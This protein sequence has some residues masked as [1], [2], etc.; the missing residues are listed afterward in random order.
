MVRCSWR[1]TVPALA[2]L[3]ASWMLAGCVDERII[4]RDREL[5]SQPQE[6]AGGFIGY[7]NEADK[8][9]VCGNCHVS[10]QARWEETGHADAWA[11]LQSSGHAQGF[12]ESCHA[13]TALGNVAEGQVGHDATKEARY[14]DVQCE[15][16]HGPGL[17][18]V[19]VPDALGLQPLAPMTVGQDM[20]F[21][22]GQCHAGAHHPFVEEWATSKHGAVLAT[23]AGRAEC[24]ECHTGEDVLRAWGI[25]ANY[26]ER[27]S[28]NIPG[29]H[30]AITCGVCH[31][32]H[33]LNHGGQLRFSVTEPNEANN[34]CMK[35]HHKRGVPDMSAQ[36]RGPHATEGPV[37]IGHAGWWPPNM[38]F[39]EGRVNATHGSEANPTLCAGCHMN[40]YT[41]VDAGGAFVKNVTGHS[42]EAIPCM[43]NGMPVPGPCEITQRNF[44]SCTGAGCHGNVSVARDRT[45]GAQNRINNLRTT[46]NGLIA[47]IPASEFNHNDNVY[48]PA[49]GARFNVQLA[50]RP[51]SAIHNP[52]LLEAL[53]SSSIEYIRDYYNLTV[54]GDVV[55]DNI[56]YENRQP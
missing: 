1:G 29:N 39:P 37:L 2:V 51:G 28:L 4:Y 14:R 50:Q 54:P 42:F 26:L 53:L 55:L 18:H 52:Y 9:T 34:L 43:E 32:P 15:S 44:T 35:C 10:Q 27:D 23:P 49:E 21:G 56:L 8:L 13:V 36:N 22:C 16:C 7:T 38:T 20:A 47:Q 25:N 19:Q 40:K 5:F 30:M 12:C 45:I 11:G 48:T 24:V 33:A 3:M 31:D 6:I 46:L 41:V 17:P